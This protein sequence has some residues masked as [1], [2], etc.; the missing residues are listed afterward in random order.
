MGDSESPDSIKVV[1]EIMA[2]YDEVYGEDSLLQLK[3]DSA[4]TDP[5]PVASV[6]NEQQTAQTIIMLQTALDSKQSEYEKLQQEL[7]NLKEKYDSRSDQD[8]LIKSKM[9]GL[10]KELNALKIKNHEYMEQN[11]ALRAKYDDLIKD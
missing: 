8:K 9:N 1:T 4:S 3:H 2:E 7:K 5:S 11:T 6:K 10:K